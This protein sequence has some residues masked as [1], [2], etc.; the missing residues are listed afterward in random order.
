LPHRLFI[1]TARLL[2]LGCCAAGMLAVAA[3]RAQSAAAS[4]T[5]VKAAFLYKFASFVEWPP[6]HFRTPADPLVIAVFGDDEVAG[7]LEHLTQGRTIE[8]RPI[9]VRRLRDPESAGR[10]H[11]LFAG[12][13]RESR[14][15]EVI[16]AVKG[17]VLT[18]ADGPVGGRPGPV[19]YFTHSEGRV[20]FGASLVAAAERGIKLS[21]RLLA[22]AQQV[23]GR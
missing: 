9:N 14:A 17:P 8:G 11:I 13:S 5:Q 2:L 12:G 3:V 15:R 4:E 20:R 10:I 1:K 7:E 23:E 16:S 18:V 19:L 21:A 22:V 6:G